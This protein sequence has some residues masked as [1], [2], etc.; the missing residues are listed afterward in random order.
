MTLQPQCA[1]AGASAWIAHSNESNVPEPPPAT[2]IVIVRAYSLPQTSHVGMAGGYPLGREEHAL[3]AT[4]PC[5]VGVVNVSP[6]SP[7]RDTAVT[8]P[9]GAVARARR[10]SAGGATIVDVGA[11][12][13]NFA[14]PDCGPE[15]ER[16]RIVP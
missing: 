9:A 3:R 5:I 16:R 15:V 13:S 11:R 7:N 6:E 14:A 1:H 4:V 12:S 2:S 10:L 8:G